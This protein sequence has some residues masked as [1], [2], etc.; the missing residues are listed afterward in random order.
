MLLGGLHLVLVLTLSN[1]ASL[2][3]SHSVSI[4]GE[5]EGIVFL[6]KQVN[7]EISSP[8]AIFN[9]SGYT[10]IPFSHLSP[11]HMHLIFSLILGPR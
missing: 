6:N 11:K 5:V 8:R 3:G 4:L 2:C 10:V 1:S 7:L 9:N